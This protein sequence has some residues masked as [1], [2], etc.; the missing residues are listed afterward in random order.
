MAHWRDWM[1]CL[2][3]FL[4]GILTTLGFAAFTAWGGEGWPSWPALIFA[5]MLNTI[6]FAA[7]LWA[8]GRLCRRP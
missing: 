3:P 1:P 7:A 8:F 2:F 4:A 5:M 6:V